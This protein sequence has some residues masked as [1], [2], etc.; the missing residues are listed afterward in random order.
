MDELQQ[1]YQYAAMMLQLAVPQWIRKWLKR[2]QQDPEGLWDM[3]QLQL[4]PIQQALT[5]HGEA[6]V[7][8]GGQEG[9]VAAGFNALAE[10]LAI[11]AFVPGGVRLFGSH[12]DAREWAQLMQVP[13]PWDAAT[14]AR[15]AAELRPLTDLMEAMNPNGKHDPTDRPAE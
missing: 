5:D 12:W 2:G 15:I 6:L 10:G 9:Q 4:G 8:G 7:A 3:M 13:F 14:E 11:L 1:R